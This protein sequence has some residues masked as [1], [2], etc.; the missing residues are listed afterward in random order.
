MDSALKQRLIG[1]AVLVALAVI[2]LPM[3]L[4]RPAPEP[5]ATSVSLDVPPAPERDFETRELEL[6]APGATSPAPAPAGPD[7]LPTVDTAAPPRTDALAGN[8]PVDTVPPAADTPATADDDA[9]DAPASS[10]PP[11]DAPAATPA[12]SATPGR[13]FAVNLGSYGNLANADAL[14][15]RMKAAGVPAYADA[16]E[17]DGKPGRRVRAG[18]FATRAEADQA[19]AS[20]RRIESSISPAVVSLDTAEA[21]VPA[22]AGEARSGFAVQV[23]AFR[24]ESDAVALRDRLRS[25]G[26]TVFT[27]DV[28]TDDGRLFRVRVGPEIERARAE[29]TLAQLRQRFGL[30]GIVVSHP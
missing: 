16:I 27:D 21:P 20:A 12:A 9:S 25:G 24:D 13:R 4:D 22:P 17:I 23:G 14:V 15:A 8:E 18:P 7:T 28:V 11:A 6:S 30:D 3:L 26:F 5:D 10:A 1:A 19:L 29:Q 2:F